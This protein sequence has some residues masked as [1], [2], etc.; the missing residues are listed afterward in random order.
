MLIIFR[1][2]RSLAL[3]LEP[4]AKTLKKRIFERRR[5]Q[6]QQ[7]QQGGDLRGRSQHLARLPSL[8]PGQ[9]AAPF[10]TSQRAAFQNCISIKQDKSRM[11]FVQEN[12]CIIFFFFKISDLQLLRPSV[13]GCTEMPKLLGWWEV[14]SLSRYWT[15]G[16]PQYRV[17]AL[18]SAGE[19]TD[20]DFFRHC[21]TLFHLTIYCIGRACCYCCFIFLSL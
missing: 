16:H 5:Q 2:V 12:I 3:C 15:G 1:T 4:P 9:I 20:G 11:D 10:V 19:R 13:T 21:N 7:Q 18:L 17:D 6:Q 8:K 14:T